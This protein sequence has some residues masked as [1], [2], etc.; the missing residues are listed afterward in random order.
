MSAPELVREFLVRRGCATHVVEGG[1]EGLVAG[2][3]RCVAEIEIGYH[4]GLHEYLNDLDGRQILHEL[5]AKLPLHGLM[6][7]RLVQADEQFVRLTLPGKR[8][9]WGEAAQKQHAWTASANAWYFREPREP[10][11]ELRDDLASR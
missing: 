1:V 2:W 6:M 9:L 8:C 11:L 10:G 4:G 5:S 7:R 3:E